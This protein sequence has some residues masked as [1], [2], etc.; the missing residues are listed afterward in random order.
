M[1]SPAIVLDD[2]VDDPQAELWFAEPPG[3]TPLPLDALLP[4][5]D[6][7]RADALREAVGPLLDALSGEMARQQFVARF[8]AGQQLLGALCESGTV[9]C[10]VGFHR[11]DVEGHRREPLLSLLTITWRDTAVAPRGVTAA[12]AVTGREGHTHLDYGEL[13][14]GP[15]AFSETTRTPGQDSGL[16]P[17]PLLQ[18]HVHLPHPDCRRLAV[19]TL[20]TTATARRKEYRAVVRQIAESVSFEDPRS[21]HPRRPA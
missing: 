7:T 18:F 8:A 17:Y 4:A 9:Y 5:L 13:A 16:P 6:S 12:R 19:L 2:S 21:G 11:D 14:C 3:F 20:S 1:S 10:A 15:A